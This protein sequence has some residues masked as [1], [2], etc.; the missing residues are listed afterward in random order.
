M[1]SLLVKQT[2]S[3]VNT[4]TQSK[5]Q[6]LQQLFGCALIGDIIKYKCFN[7]IEHCDK[8]S[9]TIHELLCKLKPIINIVGLNKN[10]VL[11]SIDSKKTEAR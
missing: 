1:S 4:A 7:Y 3:N 10:N 11:L 2:K 5:L 9:S 6:L 8:I